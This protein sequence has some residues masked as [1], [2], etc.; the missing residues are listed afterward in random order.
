MPEMSGFVEVLFV[1]N[2]LGYKKSCDVFP[3]AQG[4]MLFLHEEKKLPDM[5]ATMVPPVHRDL[6]LLN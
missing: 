6:T 5:S 2:F 3:S 1:S 4:N